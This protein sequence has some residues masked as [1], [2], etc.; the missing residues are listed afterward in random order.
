MWIRYTTHQKPDG[1]ERGSL[2]FTLFGAGVPQAAKVT[3]GPEALSR[4][5]GAFIRIG[6]SE[7]TYV[8]S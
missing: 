4:G 7:F 5:D 1:P 3:P 2:W 8:T 6:D